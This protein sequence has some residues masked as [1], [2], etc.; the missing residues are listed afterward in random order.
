M[1]ATSR[2][3]RSTSTPRAV[4]AALLVLGVL[5]SVLALSP[6]APVGAEGDPGAPAAAP[7]L[8]RFTIEV[9]PVHDLADGDEVIVTVV[10]APG[11][12]I[13]GGT[14]VV[15]RGGETYTEEADLLSS[16]TGKCPNGP[17]S[18]SAGNGT[19][20][21]VYP[22]GERAEARLRVGV[23]TTVWEF[24]A[25]EQATMTCDPEHPCPLVLRIRTTSGSAYTTRELTFTYDDP[26]IGCG[27]TATDVVSTEGP[28]RFADAWATWTF[29]ACEVPG[30][31]GAPTRMSFPGE[32]TALSSFAAG[33]ADLAYGAA[34]YATPGFEQPVERPAVRVPVA[35][36]AVVLALGGGH[37]EGTVKVP[38]PE[39]QLTLDEVTTLLAKGR[40]D[41]DRRHTA[42]IEARNPVLTPPS[43]V[44]AGLAKAVA[45]LDS[46]S[47]FLTR[48]LAELRPEGWQTRSG[49]PRSVASWLAVSTPS[50]DQVL[51]LYSGR[52][53]VAKA[54]DAAWAQAYAGALWVVTDLATATQLGLTP[55]A[56][57]N[58]AGEFV[59][60][61][62]E[63]L[64]AAVPTLEVHEDGTR[65]PVPGATAASG[66]QPYPLTYV[67]QA[68]AP[69]EELWTADCVRREGSQALLE[70]WLGHLTSDAGQAQLAPGFVPLTADLRQEAAAMLGEVGASPSPTCAD[71]VE[72]PDDGEVVPPPP[73]APPPSGPAPAPSAA[74]PSGAPVP[75]GFGP[76]GGGGTGGSTPGAPLGP[77]S[78]P[79]LVELAAATATGSTDE[80]DV[81]GFG[82]SKAPSWVLAIVVLFVLGLLL[83]GMA[84]GSSSRGRRAGG[85][86]SGRLS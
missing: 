86:S 77:I 22:G 9:T 74:F 10:A 56:I 58:A 38:Y 4:I 33:T 21:G 47:L 1:H 27:G 52:P 31:T 85:P 81:P 3:A 69:A 35:L 43:L 66:V 84:L 19:S 78:G 51:E 28:D 71:P 20:L 25:G 14:A 70:G 48:H 15:C 75:G 57:E 13:T 8:D 73:S 18:S 45:A 44:E 61:T 79:E 23:G 24:G 46:T 37:L 65:T 54:R 72:V 83:S 63:S 49:E 12:T 62:P 53:G 41:F 50:F 36:N 32:G 2:S 17:I 76:T 64:A 7:D 68:I 82:G 39:V 26:L 42:D 80:V 60:P 55:A 11:A 30:A 29:A 16:R 59:A 5:A 67:E 34:G 40:V 6:S